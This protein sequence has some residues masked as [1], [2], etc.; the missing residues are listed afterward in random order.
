MRKSKFT[1]ARIGSVVREYDAGVPAKEL[2]PKHGVS[3]KIKNE[4]NSLSKT[5][6]SATTPDCFS[7]G[8]WDGTTPA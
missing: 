5:G 4:L 7:G 8:A 3:E 2:G 6:T 1:Q